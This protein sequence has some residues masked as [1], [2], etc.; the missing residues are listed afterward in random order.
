[1]ENSQP[2]ISKPFISL[3][4]ITFNQ[5][6][7]I[8][9]SLIINLVFGIT[10]G[11]FSSF[12]SR[13]FGARY[14]CPK[15]DISFSRVDSLQH[16]LRAVIH[17]SK[18][19]HPKKILI[20]GGG[21]AGVEV[22]KRLQYRF[23]NDVSIDI[24]TVSKDNFFLFTPMLHEVASGMI[25]TRHIVTPIRA[26]CN[27]AKFYSARVELIDLKNKQIVIGSSFLLLLYL[28]PLIAG[29]TITD[30]KEQE[31]LAL[32]DPDEEGQKTNYLMTIL[33]ALRK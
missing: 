27:R 20:V 22:L 21:F 24:T 7:A 13:T 14:R 33:I 3:N 16:H 8:A 17:G 15:C 4:Q 32:A 10:L 23:Q 12:L 9:N 26:F 2:M 6:R 31:P 5:I 11:L 25:E 19:I 1:M 29:A 30:K 28:L 18:P